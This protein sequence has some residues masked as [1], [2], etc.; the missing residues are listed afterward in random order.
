MQKTVEGYLLEGCGRCSKGGTPACSVH[1]WHDILVAMR[2]LAQEC[3]LLEEVKW[4]VPCYTLNGKN[5]VMIHAFKEYCGFMFMKGALLSDPQGQLH[6]QTENVTAGRQLR[7][8]HLDDF[9]S[10]R[11]LIKSFIL[12]AIDLEKQG[13]K[14][15]KPKQ[16]ETVL[17][18][19]QD[20]FE[21]DETFKSAF[22]ALTPGRQR[23]YLL[24]FSQAKQVSTRISRIENCRSLIF[25]G[26][27][28][29]DGYRNRDL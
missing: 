15:E 7:F 3:M 25:R 1:R 21:K 8:I 12:E 9:L 10:Q 27:G 22:Y 6:R 20:L 23:G 24:H 29:H 5:V 19:L 17:K 18:E 13:K 16:S 2:V 28:L 4:S 11:D 14:I 26:E